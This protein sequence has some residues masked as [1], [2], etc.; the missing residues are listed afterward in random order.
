MKKIALSALTFLPI[1]AHA[2]MDSSQDSQ[3]GVPHER[4]SITPTV[5]FRNA[6]RPAVIVDAEFL[7]WYGE[8]SNL[9]YA[10]KRE[11]VPLGFEAL[12][13]A[14]GIAPVKKEEFDWNWN[15][16]VRLG[17]GVISSLDG[18]DLYANWTYFHTSEHESKDVA[19]F[20][21]TSITNA[22]TEFFNSPWFLQPN[23]ERYNHISA[24]WS[25]DINI[26]DLE[27]GRNFWISDELSLRPMTGVRGFWT[28]LDFKVHGSRPLTT[29]V[30]PGSEKSDFDQDS[31]GVGLLTGLS[32]SW[33]FAR[34]FSIYGDL[35]L[36]LTYG[37]QDIRRNASIDVL[38]ASETP[39][40]QYSSTLRDHRY[41]MQPFIDLGMGIR[42]ENTFDSVRAMLDLGWEFHSL[43]KF[44]QLFRGTRG[45]FN[46]NDNTLTKSDYP[47]TNGN[48]SLSGFVV[49]GRLEF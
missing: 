33:H 42:F 41:Y 16:G 11:V 45:R 29:G 44:N 23:S 17:L 27:L 22:G 26:I 19:T 1:L 31:W 43:L 12:P 10:I 37:K 25:L 47:S 28:D 14:T 40:L 21:S 8:I 49:K 24:R 7:W 13:T 48:L 15:P 3:M 20:D 36:A 38:T 46:G 9:S 30:G 6:E 2:A 32:T 35:E 39:E 4:A 5:G 18:W 34:V